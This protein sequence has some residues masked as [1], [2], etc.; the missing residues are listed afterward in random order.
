MPLGKCL[1]LKEPQV[2][3]LKILE[4]QHLP[5]N[6]AVGIKWDAYGAYQYLINENR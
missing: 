4:Y 2:C 1:D 5:N 6:I 3:Y